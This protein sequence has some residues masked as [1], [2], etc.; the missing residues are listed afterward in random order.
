MDSY[1]FMDSFG[2]VRACGS[3]RCGNQCMHRRWH[4]FQYVLS[5][6]LRAKLTAQTHSSNVGLNFQT[7]TDSLSDGQKVGPKVFGVTI[8]CKQALAMLGLFG[9]FPQGP[10][11]LARR[12]A[13]RASMPR[14]NR[15]AYTHAHSLTHSHTQRNR[16]YLVLHLHET[17]DI[18][19]QQRD[20]L[21]PR[22]FVPAPRMFNVAQ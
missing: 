6:S 13:K 5:A 3:P 4:A 10:C 21:A 2:F 12:L 15:R 20:A 9:Q 19:L 1:G 8:A 14:S 18:N 16:T 17:H 11:L 7:R 22:M